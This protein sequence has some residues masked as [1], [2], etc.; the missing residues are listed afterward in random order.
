MLW[1]KGFLGDSNPKSLLDTMLYLCG[2]HF[3]LRNGEKHRSLRLSQFELIQPKDGSTTGS[4]I[5]TE[6]YSKNNQGGLL[7]RK[8]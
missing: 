8:V 7:H 4:L 6:N 1:E 2:V 5:Y 3:A